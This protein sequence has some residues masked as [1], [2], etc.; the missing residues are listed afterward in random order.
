MIRNFWTEEEDNLLIVSKTRGLTYKE[1]QQQFLPTR[2]VNSV[3]VRGSMLI[4]NGSLVSNRAR[5]NNT[6]TT[7]QEEQLVILRLSKVSYKDIAKILNRT[8]SAIKNKANLLSKP[9]KEINKRKEEILKAI[10][11]YPS[12]NKYSGR[13]YYAHDIPHFQE[14]REVFGSWE[15][16]KKEAKIHTPTSTV[17][18]ILYYIKILKGRDIFYKIGITTKSV[19][20]RFSREKNISIVILKERLFSCTQEARNEESL[21][22]K[23]F[24][25]YKSN[26]Q[27][28]DYGGNSEVFNIDIL[29]LDA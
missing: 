21:I 9:I 13:L 1:I 24:K 25:R 11:L 20:Y 14:I 27:V 29:K 3:R 22:L 2:T 18:T 10:K 26:T 19:K 28:L 5:V 12:K 7:E 4:K 6:W 23:T 16:A 8:E 15:I 17:P